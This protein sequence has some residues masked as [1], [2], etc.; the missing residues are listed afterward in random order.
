[1]ET[2]LATSERVVEKLIV[3][4]GTYLT[5]AQ[6]LEAKVKELEEDKEVLEAKGIKQACVL[7]AYR[8]AVLALNGEDLKKFIESIETENEALKAE[9][10]QLKA[11]QVAGNDKSR[12]A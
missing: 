9:V 12:E 4:A 10:A 7:N 3:L 11:Q 1:M 2:Q 8:E 5:K 6:T